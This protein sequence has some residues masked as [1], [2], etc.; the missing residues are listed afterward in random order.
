MDTLTRLADQLLR[1]AL[2]NLPEER[3]AWGAAVL[4]EAG[5]VPAGRARLSWLLG[6]FWFVGRETRLLHA[7]GYA[8]AATM[9]SVGLVWFAWNPGSTNPATPVNRAYLITTVATLTLLPW[10]ACRLIPVGPSRSARTVRAGGYLLVW[11]L[12]PVQVGV[13]RF[14]GRRFEYFQAFN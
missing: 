5:A 4:T 6:G 10:L 9:A 7:A 14:S 3:R 12:L 1:R 8:I 11:A 13:E 2:R